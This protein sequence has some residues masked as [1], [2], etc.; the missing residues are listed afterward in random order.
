MLRDNGRWKVTIV[1]GLLLP[2]WDE[3]AAEYNAEFGSGPTASQMQRLYETWQRIQ[4][5]KQALPK[6]GGGDTPPK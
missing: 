3:L 6:D 1:V 2:S 5:H 4:E